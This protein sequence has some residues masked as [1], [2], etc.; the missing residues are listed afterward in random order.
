MRN[1]NEAMNDNDNKNDIG[2]Q[3]RGQNYDNLNEE[4][5]G[6]GDVWDSDY[7]SAEDEQKVKSILNLLG[8]GSLEEVKKVYIRNGR[9]ADKT[10][11]DL[12]DKGI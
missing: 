8:T 7:L 12:L 2:P 11:E 1:C 3:L 4:E 5:K 6:G 10:T 9:N